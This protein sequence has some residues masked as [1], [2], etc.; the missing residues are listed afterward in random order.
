MERREAIEKHR[1]MWNWIADQTEQ[2]QT[3]VGK[4]E[5]FTEHGIPL[6]IEGGPVKCEC[7]CC[8]FALEE[9]QRS[10]DYESRCI[11]CPLT[12]VDG[13]PDRTAKDENW[14]CID[15][16]SPFAAW[17]RLK[18]TKWKEA[19]RLARV[20]ANLPEKPYESD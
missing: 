11:Y 5:F 15:K 10:I 16:S 17:E 18:P 19:A 6:Y 7:F 20:I 4:T 12:W 2:R 1:E 9:K 13:Q 8:Q 14:I 3:I